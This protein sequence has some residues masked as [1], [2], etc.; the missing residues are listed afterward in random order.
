MFEV[1]IN[2]MKE[3]DKQKDSVGQ[4]IAEF[5]NKQ[6]EE[7]RDNDMPICDE[8]DGEYLGSIYWD[9]ETQTLR[10]VTAPY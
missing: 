2:K 3:I 4:E 5:I 7:L 6:L 1:Q 9:E 10:F 8:F